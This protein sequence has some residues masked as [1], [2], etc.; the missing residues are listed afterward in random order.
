MLMTKFHSLSITP[1]HFVLVLP[2]GLRF[3]ALRDFF[4][5][6]IFISMDLGALML[7]RT[8]GLCLSLLAS[9]KFRLVGHFKLCLK[10]PFLA[11]LKF[12]EPR[13]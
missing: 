13:D 9:M 4:F 2:S 11:G 6:K 10:Q 7:F 1:D 5:H 3:P 8:T 12:L